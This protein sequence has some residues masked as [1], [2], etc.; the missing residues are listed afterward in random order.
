[1]VRCLTSEG[2][3]KTNQWTVDQLDLWTFGRLAKTL[4]SRFGFKATWTGQYDS[5][6]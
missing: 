1:M 4:D 6:C 2:Q 5:T 3:T